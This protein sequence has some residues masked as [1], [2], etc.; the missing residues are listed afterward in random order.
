M[1]ATPDGAQQI[2]DFIALNN[3]KMPQLDAYWMLYMKHPW[4]AS[5]VDLIANAVSG[6]GFDIIAKSSNDSGA[7][8]SDD[9]RVPQ[10]DEFFDIAF[11]NGDTMASAM[12][13]LSVDIKVFG[14]GYWRKR[15]L[16]NKVVGLERYDPRLIFPKP[17]PDR[18]GIDCFVVKKS[19]GGQDAQGNPLPSDPWSNVAETIPPQDMI[20]FKLPGGDQVLGAP[21]PLE[22]LDHTLGL[23]IAIRRF[24]QAFFSNSGVNGKILSNEAGNRQQVRAVEAMIANSKRG[25]ENAFK[26]WIL[27]GKWKVD[28][29]GNGAGQQEFDFVKGS[30]LNREEVCAVFGVPPGL[31]TYTSN[32]LGNSGKEQDVQTF[33]EQT[34]LPLEERI[35][36]KITAELLAKE[37]GIKDLEMAPKRR[38]ALRF[39]M[40]GAANQGVQIGMTGNESR[41]LVGLPRI[42]NNPKMDEPL[43][44][45]SHG[46]TL[47]A[48]MPVNDSGAGGAEPNQELDKTNDAINAGGGKP[49]AKGKSTRAGASFY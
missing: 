15:R 12:F 39:D 45:Q 49:G 14:F 7:D 8:L 40:F 21:S 27:A 42:R 24:R 36:E 33:Q 35:F 23:D 20:F 13:T 5:C 9:E 16:L 18:R 26:T 22:K 37:Y 43:F 32:S 1:R 11:V 4:V 3:T 2:R 44:L 31:L 30:G 28:D 38:I 19:M 34:V 47:D 29:K 41:E 6:D 10:I 46:Q 48:E 25:V 17:T